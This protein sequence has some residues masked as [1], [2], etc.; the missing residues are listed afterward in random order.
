M[1]DDQQ[2]FSMI[3]EK[4]LVLVIVFNCVVYIS[5]ALVCT[6]LTT[7]HTFEDLIVC[8]CTSQIRAKPQGWVLRPPSINVPRRER[9]GRHVERLSCHDPKSS[10]RSS[11]SVWRLA[12]A[13]KEL[14][15][16]VTALYW[17]ITVAISMTAG[18][19]AKNTP[20]E[21]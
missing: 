11:A 5:I 21:P 20:T 13:S 8:I 12:P 4:D 3:S 18:A 17:A 10:G 6:W 15:R 16:Q 14:N 7:V 2:C 19:R 1:Y 9:R